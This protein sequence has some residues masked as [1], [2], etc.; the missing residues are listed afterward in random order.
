MPSCSEYT[1]E[2]LKKYDFFKAMFLAV[3]RILKCHPWNKG[4][5]DPLP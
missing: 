5:P 3:K 2:A 1:I 4:G